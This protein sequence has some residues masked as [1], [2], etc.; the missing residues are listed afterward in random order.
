MDFVQTLYTFAIDLSFIVAFIV[1]VLLILNRI[2]DRHNLIVT[3]LALHNERSVSLHV[4]ITIYN[5]NNDPHKFVDIF[6]RLSST[7]TM[8]DIK[9]FL[10]DSVLPVIVQSIW[11][12]FQYLLE[13][14]DEHIPI[15]EYV[16]DFDNMYIYGD[17]IYVILIDR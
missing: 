16:P 14:F 12:R 8:K 4:M 13:H 9:M 2:I 3:L 10:G 7:S 6:V 5:M 11:D 17:Q 1:T 15:I